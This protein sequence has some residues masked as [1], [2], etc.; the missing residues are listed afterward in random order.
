MAYAGRPGISPA[1]A[2][3]VAG[4]RIRPRH[5]VLDVGCGTGTDALLLASWGFARV[6]GVDPDARAV[7]VARRRAARAKPAERPRFER[8]SAE[9]LLET[10]GPRRF[11][12]A[13]HTLVANNLRSDRDALDEH[14]RNVAGVLR[15][16]GLLVLHERLQRRD[17]AAAPGEVAPLPAAGRWFDLSRGVTTQLAEHRVPGGPPFARVALWLGKPR[18]WPRRPRR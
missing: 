11:D 10:F 4:N 6:V 18:R 2:A 9:D 13:L 15:R 8:M 17:A 7:A 14:F 12:V 1:V 16:D 3:L 5:A